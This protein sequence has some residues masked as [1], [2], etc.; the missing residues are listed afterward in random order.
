MNSFVQKVA[1]KETLGSQETAATI[2]N[3][4][5]HFTD[6]HNYF[7][8]LLGKNKS[9]II[10]TSKAKPKIKRVKGMSQVIGSKY[11]S[12]PARNR[13]LIKSMENSFK[14]NKQAN[15][16]KSIES[17]KNTSFEYKK[18]LFRNASTTTG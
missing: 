13:N 4:K 17:N 11:L 7:G 8:I 9:N 12:S 6:H 14:T 1:K 15:F 5:R 3:M 16:T 2:G 10:S 18:G